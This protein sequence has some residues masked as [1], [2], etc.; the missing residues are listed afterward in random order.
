MSTAAHLV[1]P[2]CHAV[3]RVPSERLMQSPKCGQ[4]HAPI[5]G[6]TPV[7]LGAATFGK[8]SERNDIPLVVD[9]WAPWCGPCLSMAPEFQRAA[10]QLEPYARLA[11]V[12]TEA[13]PTLGQRFGIRSIPTMI[14]FDHGREIARTSGA[15]RA[16][17]IVRWVRSATERRHASV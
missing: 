8:H 14:V 12:D 5:F 3:N 13:E 6:G 15:M 7:A 16:A 1:C 11:K 10:G 4:C 9:F 2:G 17:D